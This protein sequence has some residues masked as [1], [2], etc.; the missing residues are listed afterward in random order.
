M[1][2]AACCR[3]T[4]SG[5]LTRIKGFD[6]GIQ[7]LLAM[8]LQ[9]VELTSPQGPGEHTQNG[10]HQQHRQGNEHVDDVHGLCFVQRDRRQ[11]LS[12]T[13]SELL[14]M[15]RPAAQGGSMPAKARGTHTKL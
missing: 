4:P 15:P 14:A 5:T 11:A 2:H 13:T 7:D 3:P 1:R 12:T 10:E 9:V 6:G 8:L